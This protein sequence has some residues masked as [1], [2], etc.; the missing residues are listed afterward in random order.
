MNLSQNVIF[1]DWN[2]T[3][4]NDAMVCVEAMN[5]MLLKRGRPAINIQFYQTIFDFPVVFGHEFSARVL[6]CGPGVEQLA[7]HV[8]LTELDVEASAGA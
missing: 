8:H 1:W 4:L 3:L 2:G 6:R 7:R 5:A